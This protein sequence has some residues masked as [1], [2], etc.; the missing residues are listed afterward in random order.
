MVL[1]KED[2]Y[3]GGV[4]G[5]GFFTISPGLDGGGGLVAEELGSIIY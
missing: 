1:Y 4:L 3:E 2:D 5:E